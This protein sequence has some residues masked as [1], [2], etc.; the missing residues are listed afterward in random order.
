VP[1]ESDAGLT[2]VCKQPV[3]AVINL[4]TLELVS[5]C[6]QGGGWST[7]EGKSKKLMVVG[8]KSIKCFELSGLTQ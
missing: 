7:S 6:S 2:I 4:L 3:F 5:D 1:T 8:R